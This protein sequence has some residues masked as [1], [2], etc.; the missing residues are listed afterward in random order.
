MLACNIHVVTL[1]SYPAQLAYALCSAP[2][3]FMKPCRDSFL[4]RIFCI[5]TGNRFLSPH[6]GGRGGEGDRGVEA[7]GHGPNLVDLAGISGACNDRV[8]L[9]ESD[10]NLL[11]MG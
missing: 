11:Q 7:G 9:W 5:I 3:P 4:N 10:P 1:S 2:R 8:V 6:R